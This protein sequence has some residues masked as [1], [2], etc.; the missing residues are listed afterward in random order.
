MASSTMAGTPLMRPCRTGSLIVFLTLT[1]AVAADDRN[2]TF[3]V[4]YRLTDTQHVLVRARINGKGP[5]NFILDTGAP[6]LFVVTDVARRLGIEADRSGW[7]TLDR[8]EVE[9]GV[10]I[11]KAR[12]RIETPFQLEGINGLG[13][14][15]APVHG[16]I[17]YTVLA[18]FRLEFDFTRDRMRWTRLDFTPP[19]PM[20]LDGAGRA[21]G[22]LDTLGSLLKF[23]GMVIGKKAVRETLPRGF[24]GVEL[25]ERDGGVEVRAVLPGSPAADAGIRAGDRITRFEGK[26]VTSLAGLRRA[27]ARFTAGRAARVGLR[28]A[29]GTDEV[30][31]RFGEGL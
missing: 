3:R 30:T 12:A 2:K 21:A 29:S 24:L 28:R 14:A 6:A 13:L 15:G 31:V 27:A 18:R 9:G 17:G 23:L 16:M 11:R 20:R 1:A 7:A 4:P 22:G 26:E 5:F 25:A 8:F 19:A 10:E